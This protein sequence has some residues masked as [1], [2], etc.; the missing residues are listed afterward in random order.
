M[1]AED[2]TD[3]GIGEEPAGERLSAATACCTSLGRARHGRRRSLHAEPTQRAAHAICEP[4][5]TRSKGK[6]LMG[7]TEIPVSGAVSAWHRVREQRRRQQKRLAA[8][9]NRSPRHPRTQ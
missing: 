5:M 3:F 4:Q 9:P 2:D 8:S 7:T 1:A 6:T